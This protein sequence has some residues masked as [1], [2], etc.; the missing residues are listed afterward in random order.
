[1]R[2]PALP[3]TELRLTPTE[4]RLILTASLGLFLST[5]DSGI[6]TVALP[7]LVASL[8]TSV[9]TAAWTATLYLLT[10]AVTLAPFGR[11]ADRVG[12]LRVYAWGLAVFGLASALCA[13]APTISLLIGARGL[14]GVGAA[15]LQATSTALITTRIGAAHRPAALG[16]LGMI[17]GLGPVLGPS[18][19]GLLLSTLGWP[20]VFWLNLPLCALGWWGTRRL[21]PDH[22]NPASPALDWG[23]NALLG[24]SVLGLLLALTSLA[25]GHRIWL[26]P[27]WLVLGALL[28]AAFVRREGRIPAPLLP[29]AAWRNPRLTALLLATAG[30]GTATAVAFVAPPFLWEGVRHLPPWQVG[31]FA[32]SAPLGL[33]IFARVSG[34]WLPRSGPRRLALLGLA[35]MLFGLLCLS[36]VGAAWSPFL[37]AGWLFVYG[38]GAGLM[39]PAAV[40]GITAAVGPNMQGTI[41]AVQRLVQNLGIALGTAGTAGLLAWPGSSGTVQAVRL[42]FLAAALVVA[43]CVLLLGRADPKAPQ[44]SE[45]AWPR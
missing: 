4:R 43:L 19:G 13:L 39:L 11:L 40:S 42:A 25:S 44:A 30:L 45:P 20:W 9:Q 24:G 26:A 18:V 6:V 37:V 21:A 15:L 14:Q 8:H 36:A 7:S 27:A 16:T 38:V 3:P 5:L 41:G 23:G 12:R 32:L 35:V 1:M 28:A 33:A 22:P 10:L 2:S 29:L 34:A 31:F 17:Q